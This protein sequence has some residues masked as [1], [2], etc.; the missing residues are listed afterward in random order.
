MEHGTP[1]LLRSFEVAYAMFRVAGVSG[2]Q[3]IKDALERFGASVIEHAALGRASDLRNVIDGARYMLHL[4]TNVGS[5]NIE[6]AETIMRALDELGVEAERSFAAMPAPAK[7]EDIF[8]RPQNAEENSVIPADTGIRVDQRV[9]KQA[10][11]LKTSGERQSVIF[12]KIRQSGNC[13]LRDIQEVLPEVSERTIRYDI[14]YLIGNGL[15]ERFGSGGP[16]T[17]Y[18]IRDRVLD[19]T[20]GL[21]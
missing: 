20:A 12:Q 21:P 11:S 5:V 7:L 8:D 18:R 14:D 15:I 10:S 9:P 3:A 13:R 16:A 6:N 2:S 19:A 17:F 1:I 4:G